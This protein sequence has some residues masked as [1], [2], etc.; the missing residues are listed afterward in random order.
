MV[1]NTGAPVTFFLNANYRKHIPLKFA[2][3]AKQII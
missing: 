2:L 3:I 1:P